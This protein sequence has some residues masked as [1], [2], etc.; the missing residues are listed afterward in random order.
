MKIRKIL[1]IFLENREE[2]ESFL[3]FPLYCILKMI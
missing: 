2:A 3:A 1:R